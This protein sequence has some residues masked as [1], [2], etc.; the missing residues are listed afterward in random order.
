M[1]AR[2]Y[3]AKE[4]PEFKQDGFGYTLNS[5]DVSGP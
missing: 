5:C 1:V 3:T 4:L 2:A